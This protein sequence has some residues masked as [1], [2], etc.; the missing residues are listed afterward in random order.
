MVFMS[1]KRGLMG[2]GPDAMREGDIVVTLFGGRV[3]DLLKPVQGGSEM[4][5]RRKQ[6]G[7]LPAS[8][9]L[10]SLFGDTYR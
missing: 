2:I 4:E 1:R 10:N 8:L 5:R 9:T 7:C 3:P 6:E